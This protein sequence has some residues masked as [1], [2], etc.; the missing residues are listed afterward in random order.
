MWFHT[1]FYNSNLVS[2]FGIYPF[3]WCKFSLT[4]IVWKLVP[5]ICFLLTFNY[6]IFMYMDIWIIYQY[7]V[8]NSFINHII[9]MQFI[10]SLGFQFLLKV[11][12]SKIAWFHT[13]FSP[14][15]YWD[16]GIYLQYGMYSILVSSNFLV[17]FMCIKVDSLYCEVLWILTNA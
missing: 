12:F 13:F 1:N 16:Q 14:P 9:Y 7:L 15:L 11:S 5:I 8:N 4:P 10:F 6:W 3:L 2:H 17:D